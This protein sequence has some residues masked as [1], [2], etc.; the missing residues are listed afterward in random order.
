MY[1]GLTV[2]QV[3]PVSISSV[4]FEETILI[5]MEYMTTWIWGA[6][7]EF[8][9][10][11]MWN[12]GTMETIAISFQYNNVVMVVAWECYLWLTYHSHEEGEKGKLDG[13]KEIES[14]LV[15]VGHLWNYGVAYQQGCWST[16]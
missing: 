14:M 5:F 10:S 4:V 16:S 15:K 7:D 12:T 11:K 1:T 3:S 2:I 6:N 13:I 9:L 8:S